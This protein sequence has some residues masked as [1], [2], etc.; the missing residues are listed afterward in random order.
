MI[1]E[2]HRAVSAI[3]N[4][5]P[6]TGEAGKFLSPAE[7]SKM[8]VELA[9]IIFRGMPMA[10]IATV[11]N[12]IITVI[13]GW[14]M[15]NQI[16]LGVWGGAVLALSILRL[17]F[18]GSI[19]R[20]R[21]TLA[22]MER[23][24]SWN[25]AAMMVNG[26]LWGALAPIF[27]VYGQIGHVFLP[28]IIAGISA[29]AIVSA[30]ACWRSVLAFNIPA[31]L[32]MAVTFFVWGGDGAA[33]V[34]AVII[35]YGIMTG[36]LAIQTSKMVRRAI[37]LRSK[38]TNLTQ[39][40]EAKVDQSNE[41]TKRFRALV[42]SS[43][44]MTLIFS[45]EGRITYASP[46]VQDILGM[47][48][49]EMIGKTTIDLVH[50]DDLPKFRAAGEEALSAVGEV[51]VMAHLCLKDSKG[52]FVAMSGRLSNFLYVPGIEGFVFRGSRQADLGKRR[53]HAAE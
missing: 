1:S 29:A 3:A 16:V 31:L 9:T 19:K 38:N 27:A 4:P 5:S 10:V 48:P 47:M 26:A 25:M 50:D 13:V 28:F 42:E 34:S 33:L 18:W 8:K 43:R 35:V 51:R 15:V 17:A 44:E 46:A 52:E 12:M 39:A 30:G 20:Q 41:E 24:R 49:D 32:P 22:V 36:Y 21:P 14:G 7:K 11:L 2:L 40:L 6:L 37:F 45:P 53:M 23:F